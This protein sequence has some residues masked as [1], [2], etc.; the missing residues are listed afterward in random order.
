MRKKSIL[1]LITILSIALTGCESKDSGTATLSGTTA[2]AVVGGTVTGEAQTAV[3]QAA[4]PDVPPGMFTQYDSVF[5][6]NYSQALAQANALLEQKAKFCGIVAEVSGKKAVETSKQTFYFYSDNAK[7]K[8]W[9]VAESF[10]GLL[11][12]NVRLFVAKS[13]VQELICT[14]TPTE[15]PL[16]FT[17]FLETFLN[18]PK[19][20][21]ITESSIGKTVIYTQKKGYKLELFAT[22]GQSLYSSALETAVQNTRTNPTPTTQTITPSTAS[23]KPA[24]IGDISY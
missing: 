5:L 2:T 24:S 14:L 9:Y 13:D 20:S 19:S 8:D 18:D 21:A 16:S 3:S 22:D 23:T 12:K 10:D 7:M 6:N 4:V 1:L 11:K 15:T 17:D